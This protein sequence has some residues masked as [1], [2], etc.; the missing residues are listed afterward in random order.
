MCVKDS[1]A[2][3]L[4]PVDRV[5]RGRLGIWLLLELLCLPE[6]H[7]VPPTP[8]YL[9]DSP[10]HRDWRSVVSATAGSSVP[11]RPLEQRPLAHL[12]PRLPDCTAVLRTYWC[13]LMP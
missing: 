1:G 7:P 10:A 8:E 12:S 11:S 5:R 4:Y 13:T 9:E 6:T 3:S 2:G